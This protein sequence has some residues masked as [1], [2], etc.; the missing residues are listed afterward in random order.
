M[1]GWDWP[2]VRLPRNHVDLP[3]APGGRVEL[4]ERVARHL[5]QVLRLREGA[6]ILLFNGRDGRDY[7]ARLAHLRKGTAQ[8]EI[9]EAREVEPPPP[10]ALHLALGISRGE[11]MDYALQ[12]AVELGVA[13]LQPLFTERTV[14]RLEGKRLEK[15]T[16]HWQGVVTSACEQSGRRYLPQLHAPL[17]L[18]AWLERAAPPVLLLDPRAESSLPELPAPEKRLTFLIGPEG[19]LNEKERNLAY[20]RGCTGVRLGPRVLR[21]ETAPLAALA[22]AQVLWGDFC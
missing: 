18:A 15:R 16:A 20:A 2:T 8:A 6:R 19:G 13:S 5:L 3:L 9:L 4:P 11:R 17:R 7:L 1:S 22:A 14:V 12:K 10:L 21:T